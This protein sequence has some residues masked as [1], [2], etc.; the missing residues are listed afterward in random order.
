[1]Y[2]WPAM[3]VMVWLLIGEDDRGGAGLVIIDG[4]TCATE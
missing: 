3:V 4:G 2:F 1:M